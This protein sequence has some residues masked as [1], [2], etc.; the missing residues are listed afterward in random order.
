MNTTHTV[1]VPAVSRR[2]CSETIP[3]LM[4]SRTDPS[5]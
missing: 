1:R 2:A 4:F 3:P 5:Q